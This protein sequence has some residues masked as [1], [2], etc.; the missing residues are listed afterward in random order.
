MIGMIQMSK[1]WQKRQV[2]Q[3]DKAYKKSQKEFDKQLAKY[4]K[5]TIKDLE[6]L[7]TD[8]YLDILNSDGEPTLNELYR[9]N[10]FYKMR[11]YMSQKLNFLN[12]FTISQLI[13]EIDNLYKYTSKIVIDNLFINEPNKEQ[14][15]TVLKELW[16]ANTKNWSKNVWCKD[17][18]DIEQ[19]VA[20]NMNKLQKTIE[21]GIVDCVARGASKDELV[22]TLVD[23][24]NVSFNEANRLART[25]LTYVQNQATMDSYKKANVEEYEYLSAKDN[26]V[27][28][29]CLEQNGKKYKVSEAIVGVNYPPLHVNC[30]CTTIAVI[31]P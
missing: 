16:D 3:R 21:K 6:I 1:Y 24:F 22:K 9:F 23:R 15:D 31:N 26:R 27:S 19:R 29:I 28:P 2:E 4:Y 7:I 5:T 25:E 11:Q 12:E 14:V 17:G 10:R 30:R 20:Q 18:K 8:L 13:T